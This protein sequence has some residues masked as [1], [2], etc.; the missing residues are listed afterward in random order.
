MGR[1]VNV[2]IIGCGLIGQKRAKALG[3]ATVTI[4]C[5]AVE[6]RTR[7]IASPKTT[8]NWR[9]AVT[10]DDVDVVLVATTN[11]S[12]AEIALGAIEAGKHVL[13]EKPAGRGVGE[14][15]ALIAAAKKSG[16]IVRVGF[17][18]RYHPALLK[19]R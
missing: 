17:N 11:A 1:R 9:E 2:A 3:D 16:S 5:D 18:H 6:E 7:A 14:I 15:D 13:I 4:V 19:A 12:L 8:T 10:R